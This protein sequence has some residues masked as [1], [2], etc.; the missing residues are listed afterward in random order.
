MRDQLEWLPTESDIRVSILYGR[1]SACCF[2]AAACPIPARA[3]TESDPK[4][5]SAVRYI[6]CE[7]AL[8]PRVGGRY[9]VIFEKCIRYQSGGISHRVIIAMAALCYPG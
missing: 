1:A 5:I 3:A 8:P 9:R 7:I 2:R 6:G 4:E